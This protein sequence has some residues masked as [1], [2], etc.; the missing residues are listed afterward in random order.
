MK[1]VSGCLEIVVVPGMI[2]TVTLASNPYPRE[3]GFWWVSVVSTR[4]WPAWLRRAAASWQRER[5]PLSPSCIAAVAV[6]AV[7]RP[8]ERWPKLTLA[9]C[10]VPCGLRRSPPP[11][12]PTTPRP[13]DRLLSIQVCSSSIRVHRDRGVNTKILH[14]V[15]KDTSWWR[16]LDHYSNYPF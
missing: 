1:I 11:S 2:V 10:S 5:R 15:N 13:A 3:G 16:S 4:R 12:E 8:G 7:S 9:S 6:P 14:K